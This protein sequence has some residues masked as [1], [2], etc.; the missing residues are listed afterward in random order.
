MILNTNYKIP[1]Q[2]FH[3][4]CAAVDRLGF[5]AAFEIAV[6]RSM[7][8]LFSNPACTVFT[9]YLSWSHNIAKYCESVVDERLKE[10]CRIASA[11]YRKLAHHIYWAARRYDLV[12]LN[13]Y[14]MQVIK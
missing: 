13:P 11:F 1:D 10:R 5:D 8:E 7:Q 2:T 4:L 3:S 6:E 14:F 12:E 9:E